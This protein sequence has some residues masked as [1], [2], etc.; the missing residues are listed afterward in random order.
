MVERSRTS[1]NSFLKEGVEGIGH[2]WAAIAQ[3]MYRM[4]G[5]RIESEIHDD[6]DP[7]S[8]FRKDKEAMRSDWGVVNHDIQ[9][10]IDKALQEFREKAPP[11]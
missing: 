6:S 7:F 5:G 3:G 1:F 8:G 11:K 10:Q 9:V 4:V 2:G